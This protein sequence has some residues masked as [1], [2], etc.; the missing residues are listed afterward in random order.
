VHALVE[1][2]ES[3]TTLAFQSA[4]SSVRENTSLGIGFQICAY[5]ARRGEPTGSWSAVGQ[6]AAIPSYTLRP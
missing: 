2:G 4:C 1:V 6:K 3:L 5:S